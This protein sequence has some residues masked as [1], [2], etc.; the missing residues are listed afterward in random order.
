MIGQ[1]DH[2]AGDR[3][4]PAEPVLLF[5]QLNRGAG[6]VRSQ[7]GGEARCT[8]ANDQNIYL[9]VDYR[10]SP[11]IGLANSLSPWRSCHKPHFE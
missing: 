10:T 5:D 3:G 1:P 9:A 4:G 8:G 2:T 6:F 11:V 7:S